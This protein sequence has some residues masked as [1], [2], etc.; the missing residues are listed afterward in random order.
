MCA[1]VTELRM[2]LSE[3][4]QVIA[5]RVPAGDRLADIGTD[6][7]Q[8]PVWLYAKGICPHVILTDISAE[9]L[10]KAKETAAA[11]QFGSGME[12]RVGSGLTVLEPGEV[13]TVIIAGMG[14]RLIRDILGTDPEHAESFR[15]LIL[16]PRKGSGLLRKWLLENGW[17]IAAEDVVWESHFLP[18][19][20]TATSPAFAHPAGACDL[21]EDAR[22]HLKGLDGT[23]IRLR[24]PTWMVDAGGP[25]REYLDMRRYQEQL[26]LTNMQRAKTRNEGAEH[27]V[28]ENIG[29]LEELRNRL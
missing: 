18:E 25:V 8:I 16:Q 2:T 24:V 1:Q 13:D 29:Y 9:S 3:R 17:S 6:H 22:E 10:A 14:G 11:Y 12:F 23:D 28:R 27:R 26:V 5:D 19:I 15:R 4:M 20:I 21:S 7:G